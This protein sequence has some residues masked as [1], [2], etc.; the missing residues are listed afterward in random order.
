MVETKVTEFNK[1]GVLVDIG[2]RG[3]VPMSQLTSLGPS[4]PRDQRDELIELLSS[5]VGRTIRVKII[6]MD[7]RR[8]RLILSERAAEREARGQAT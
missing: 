2:P 4:I 1:G 5:L 3:F 8:N 6:E 7:K